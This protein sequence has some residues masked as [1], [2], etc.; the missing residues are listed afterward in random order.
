MSKLKD[1]IN[2]GVTNRDYHAD[3]TYLSSSSLKL[4]LKDVEQF[5][6]EKI[7]GIRPEEKENPAFSEGSF[8]HSM[9]LEPE[10]VAAEYAFFEG[11]RKQ[12]KDFDLFKKENSSKI[13]LSKPQKFRCE[14]YVDA[15]RRLP[16]AIELLSGGM[17]EYTMCNKILNVPIKVR[18]DYINIDKGYIVDIKTT[19][20]PSSHEVFKRT[21]KDYGYDLSAALYCQVAHDINGKL[22]DFYFVV[23]SKADFECQ[24]YKA[25]S[26]TLTDGH[27]QVNKAL[28]RYKKCLE[29]GI[30]KN[31]ESNKSLSDTINSV[32]DYVIEEV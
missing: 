16:P 18:A 21:V 30:W 14:K 15:Y 9:I 1:G 24:V 7:L 17:P 5:H 26:A 2:L 22:F 12:G 11:W 32:H 10:T 20:H 13:I 4:L 31:D 23:I 28:I 6:K 19:A 3:S 8:V 25:S 27:T 29:S